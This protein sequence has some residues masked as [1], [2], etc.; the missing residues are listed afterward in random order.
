MAAAGQVSG[1]RA[2]DQPAVGGQVR[3]T[4]GVDGELLRL[5]VVPAL[6]LDTNLVLAVTEIQSRQTAAASRQHRIADR[7]E[8][9]QLDAD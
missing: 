5:R 6:M 2:E 9:F 4:R 1:G 7:H 8:F 3:V